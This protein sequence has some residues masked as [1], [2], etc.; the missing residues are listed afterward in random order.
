MSTT[1]NPYLGFN[2]NCREA[3]EFYTG[4]L[5]GELELM[6]MGEAPF[7]V[8]KEAADQIM[9]SIIRF[10]DGAQIMGSDG[11]PGKD[12]TFGT[13]NSISIACTDLVE[14]ERIFTALAK[15]GEI[16]MPFEDTFWGAKFGTLTD[17]FGVLWMVNCQTEGSYTK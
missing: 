4:V 13:N 14:A 12:F 16:T 8:P 11:M 1:C 15:D 6:P 2:G 10:G 9:H 17:K 5:K 7:E 3:M